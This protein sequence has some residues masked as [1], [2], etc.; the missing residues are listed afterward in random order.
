MCYSS[1]FLD[2]FT[3][4]KQTLPLLHTV[5]SKHIDIITNKYC[6]NIGILDTTIN[7]MLNTF[8]LSGK[9]LRSIQVL[10]WA[11][12]YGTTDY[13]QHLDY[14]VAM[15]F[16]QAFLLIHDDVMDD[17]DTRRGNKSI[18]IQFRD[19][20]QNT[21]TNHLHSSSEKFKREGNSLAICIGDILYAYTFEILVKYSP[22]CSLNTVIH[23]L[24]NYTA[25]VGSGQFQ[26]IVL[27]NITDFNRIRTINR[28][29]ILQMY[30]RKTGD[31]T[32]SLPSI[33][34]MLTSKKL[35]CNNSMNEQKILHKL[36]S[37]MGIMYQ[38]QDD[39]IGVCMSKNISGK[40]QGADFI[41][42]KITL[43]CIIL[44]E[45]FEFYNQKDTIITLWNSAIGN[46]EIKTLVHY[47]EKFKVIE[48]LRDIQ[49][50]KKNDAY[51]IVELLNIEKVCRAQIHKL[52]DFSIT[53]TK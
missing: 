52:I 45:Q 4:R 19:I 26:D 14:A 17:D 36:G 29:T 40:V 50:E 2:F 6:N 46:I 53:R 49:E 16:L 21:S 12:I 7:G 11:K 8:L 42:K 48:I 31:Y 43:L 5:I 44:F 10:Y 33:L 24:A 27:T 35:S 1:E 28:E 25:S 30:S 32:F 51:K 41:I 9:M 20:I 34:G 47:I 23:T 13:L 3:F 22:Q 37:V 18:H 15:E 39:I 38:I